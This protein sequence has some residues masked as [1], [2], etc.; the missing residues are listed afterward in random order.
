MK[1]SRVVH[2]CNPQAVVVEGYYYQFP[3]QS[4]DACYQKGQI[5][6]DLYDFVYEDQ[7][8]SHSMYFYQMTVVVVEELN[9]HY[10]DDL[11]H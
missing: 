3:G 8:H 2:Y 6:T 9:T 5:E 11:S 1:P 7:F 4:F 10:F